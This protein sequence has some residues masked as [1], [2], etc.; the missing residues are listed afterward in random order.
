LGSAESREF[1]LE[2][3]GFGGKGALGKVGGLIFCHE[4]IAPP[5]DAE[6]HTLHIPHVNATKRENT[7]PKP[8]TTIPITGNASESPSPFLANATP[9]IIIDRIA[10][11]TAPKLKTVP[12]IGKKV[13]KIPKKELM[14]E[15]S[16][17][18]KEMSP[19]YFMEKV[20]ITS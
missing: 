13:R 2:G 8:P 5:I 6:L 1:V 16:D 7:R 11:N 3:E 9:P 17:V 19:K 14:R 4:G 12:A 10:K 18:K 15:P 20:L